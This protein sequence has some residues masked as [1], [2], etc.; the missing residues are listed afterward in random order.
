MLLKQPQEKT[1]V[2]IFVSDTFGETK[3]EA[4]K[5]S[6][7]K[8]HKGRPPT[9]RWCD[10]DGRKLFSRN[11]VERWAPLQHYRGSK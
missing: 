6:Y 5:V 10:K 9:W 3:Y 1:I 4:M 7:K 2:N 11:E 8:G